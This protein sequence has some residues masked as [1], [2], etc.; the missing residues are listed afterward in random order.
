M[1]EHPD[2][3]QTGPDS[4]AQYDYIIVGAGSAGCV[5]AN[6]LS[7][8]RLNRV[9]V[10]EAGGSDLSFWIQMPIGYGKS[11]YNKNVNWMYRTEPDPGLGGRSGYWPRGKVLG[12]SSSIN[13]M[14]YIRGQAEDFDAWEALGNPGW[15]WDSVLPYFKKSENNERGGNTWRG[16][17]GPLHVSDVSKQLHP[18]NQAYLKAAEEAGLPYNDD[19][20]GETQEGAG[21]Y[22]ITTRN[23][24]RMSAARAYLRPAMK[25]AN[26]RVETKAKATRIRFEGDKAVGIEYWQNGCLHRARAAREVILSAGSINSPQLLQL[27]G[28]GPAEVLKPLGIDMVHESPAVGRNL[29]DHL[30]LDHVYRSRV[31][32]LNEELRPWWGK[33]R[34]GLQY[35]L[36]RQGPLSLSVN[37]GGGFFKTRPDLDRPNMQLY[38]S[39]VSYTKAPPGK[40]PMMSP[41]PYPGFLI[42][43]SPCRPTS[44]GHLQI[45]STNPEDPPEIHPNSIS[46]N[47]DLQELLEG[48]RFLRKLAA[49]S[50]LS[51]VIE[52]ETQPGPGVESDDAMIEYIRHRST[53]VFHPVSTCR[54]GPAPE[55]NVV[56]HRLRVHGLRNLRV[57]DA[58]IFPAVTSGNTNAPSIMVGEKGADMILEDGRLP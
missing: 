53:T 41:D 20:N 7:E 22:Q 42:S 34:A 8:E 48:S 19:F 23:G 12:G 50:S 49:T 58:S 24:F 36:L 18:L 33:L 25:R 16:T 17:G 10:L 2:R 28:V 44:R 39:P 31:P 4:D 40:R 45:R 46:T 21:L 15:G 3:S 11:F 57:V 37:Q 27:S 56:D 13:A 5:L 51:A 26:L 55:E 54:M 52:E 1:P 38:F 30:C 32:T 35:V 29:Q 43:V 6:R 9:L 14:V 47:H